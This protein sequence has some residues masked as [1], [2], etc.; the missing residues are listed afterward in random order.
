M[1][2]SNPVTV[3]KPRVVDGPRRI[4]VSDS[5][6]SLFAQ[7]VLEELAVLLEESA[8]QWY[9]QRRRDRVAAALELLDQ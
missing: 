4:S 2:M 8:P 7:M 9:T 5:T 3:L 1:E 6:R